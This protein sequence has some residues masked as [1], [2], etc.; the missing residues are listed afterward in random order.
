MFTH[1]CQQGS[2]QRQCRCSYLFHLTLRFMGEEGSLGREEGKW[3]G[4]QN[5]IINMKQAGKGKGE[6]LQQEGWELDLSELGLVLGA[7]KEATSSDLFSKVLPSAWNGMGG[8][9]LKNG[10]QELMEKLTQNAALHTAVV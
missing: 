4:T 9:Q 5:L 8:S 3:R 7:T 10:G 6:R 2:S 1:F